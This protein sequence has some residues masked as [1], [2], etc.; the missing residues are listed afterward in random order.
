MEK[1]KRSTNSHIPPKTDPEEQHLEK[2]AVDPFLEHRAGWQA[3]VYV[4]GEV[5]EEL[6]IPEVL[7]EIVWTGGREE[8]IGYDRC[9]QRMKPDCF[10]WTKVLKML[11]LVMLS[12]WEKP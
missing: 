8:N 4:C 7:L 12:N 1:E 3:T 2:T 6:T 10:C 9:L 11:V 5:V